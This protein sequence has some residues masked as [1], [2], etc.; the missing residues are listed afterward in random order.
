LRTTIHTVAHAV[1]VSVTTVSRALNNTG[2]VSPAT[3]KEIIRV[4]AEL[5]YRAGDTFAPVQPGQRALAI[6]LPDMHNPFIPDILKGARQATDSAGY[7][8]LMADVGRDERRGWSNLTGLRRKRVSGVVVVASAIHGRRLQAATEGIPVV[9]FDQ[10]FGLPGASTIQADQRGGAQSATEHLW[11]LGH[12]DI[13]HLAGPDDEPVAIARRQGFLEVLEKHGADTT[14]RVIPAGWTEDDGYHATSELLQRGVRF[15]ALLAS[16]DS[17]AIGALSALDEQGVRVPDEVSVIG[18]DDI[19]LTNYTHPRLTTV[20]QDGV[21][22]GAAAVSTIL[23]QV[24]S[25]FF[26]APTHEVLPTEL[27]VRDST[28]RRPV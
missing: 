7:L 6:I 4:A 17:C 8:L 21:R 16:S 11:M 28:S 14:D 2:R 27:I 9:C 3:R 23:R 24:E 1:G 13:L 25:G 18:F 5:G 20:R 10:D 22:L 15:T 12:R 19:Q 26:A